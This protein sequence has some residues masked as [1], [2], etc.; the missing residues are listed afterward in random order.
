M[1]FRSLLL[2][3]ALVPAGAMELPPLP[4]DAVSVMEETWEKGIDPARWYVM[5]RHWGHGHHGVVPDNVNVV[6]ETGADG[7]TRKILVCKAHGDK[8][9]GPVRG[10]W[11]RPE[12]VGG[13]IASKEFFASGRF[14]VEMRVGGTEKTDEG[15][16]DPARPIGTIPAIWLYAGWN[17]KVPE[18]V[19]KNYVDS[20]PFYQPYLQEWG[21]GNAF[22]WSE[23]DFPELG[24]Q[25]DFDHGLYNTF[26]NKQNDSRTFPVKV[27]DGKFHTYTTEWRTG[28]TELK[29]VRDDQVIEHAGFWWIR[30]LE[31]PFGSYWGCPLK[32]L[33]PDR[34][35]VYLG[36]V[37]RHWIDGKFAGENTELVPSIAAQ[38]SL[39]VWLPDWAGP[40]PWE[41]SQVAFGTIR[42]WQ[43]HDEG[44]VRGFLTNDQPDNI[45]A[46]GNLL[47]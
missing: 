1:M 5:R 2:L 47:Q 46:D 38:L 35:A 12:R 10:L 42:V 36:K 40:A 23:I 17:T 25:G 13:V 43:Y 30:D 33:G 15:P 39:G 20:N 44:D 26:L 24:K 11:N 31:V 21:P 9:E 18:E 7:K 6:E 3:T 34:Y 19:S 28:L 29:D 14:E 22:Y 45:G 16:A 27:A 4:A 37:A 8:Y 32:K 41:T